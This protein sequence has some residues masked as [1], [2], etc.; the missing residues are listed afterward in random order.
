MNSIPKD[1]FYGAIP[2]LILNWNGEEDTLECLNSIKKSMPAGFVPV[3]LDNGSKAESLERLKR[4]CEQIFSRI[5]FLK[6][7]ELST[8]GDTRRTEFR[9]NLLPGNRGED[10]MVFI[11][12]GENLGFAKGNNVGIRFAE[13]IGAEWVML[14]NNDTAVS[15]ETFQ[16]LRRFQASYPQFPAITAQVR[17]YEPRTRIQNCGGRLTYFGSRKYQ[18][19][20]MDAGAL[21]ES[22][23]S[24]V[25]FVTGC[26]LLFNYKVTGPLTEDFFFGEEDYEFSLRMRD[27]GL[28][29]ACA[30]RA[31]VYHKLAATTRRSSNPIGSILLQYVNRLV[32]TRNHYSRAMW[33]TTRILAYMHMPILLRRNG[34]DPSKCIPMIRRTEAYLREHRDVPRAEFES[35]I[36]E[37]F[38]G[39]STPA[40]RGLSMPRFLYRKIFRRDDYNVGL[41]HAPIHRFLEPHWRPEI[42]WL[43]KRL[44]PGTF[45]ADPFG[46]EFEGK[47]YLLCEYFDYREPNGRIVAG[48]MRDGILTGT[49]EDAI[50]G[51]CHASYPFLFAHEGELFCIPETSRANEVALFKMEEFP[52]RWKKEAVLLQLDAVDP[53]IVQYKGQWWLFYGLRSTDGAELFVSYADSPCGPWLPHAKQPIKRDPGSARP[54]GTPF[55]YQGKLYRPAQD[56]SR[57]YGRRLVIQEVLA[58]SPTEFEEKVVAVVEPDENGPYPDGLHTLSAFGE[59][60][61]VDG[62]REQFI[63]AAVARSGRNIWKRVTGG[64]NSGM[65]RA[66]PRAEEQA[67]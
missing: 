1:N 46:I 22:E 30:H 36:H 44:R 37:G 34:M 19:A 17:Y 48:E 15:P 56:C 32:N 67:R 42:H 47:R 55:V 58:L 27:L 66:T 29:M 6:A 26:A 45:I 4:E 49:L 65:L 50:G 43:P 8:C 28:K 41:V 23:Y 3:V 59:T 21:P 20:E 18:Y 9:E 13:S 35:M 54:G 39:G 33:N 14:L 64:K 57:G 11:E 53:S 7:E 51:P 31:I 63:W 52:S 38:D 62:K 24:E 61:L 16:E 10:S 60:T 40:S 2:V 25:S 5:F 12:N